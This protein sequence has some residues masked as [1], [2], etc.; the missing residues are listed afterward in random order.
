MGH[1]AQ[2]SNDFAIPLIPT[3]AEL[4]R[5]SGNVNESVGRFPSAAHSGCHRASRFSHLRGMGFAIG[6]RAASDHLRSQSEEMEA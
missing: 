5:I 3:N 1:P 4:N 6:S 2:I